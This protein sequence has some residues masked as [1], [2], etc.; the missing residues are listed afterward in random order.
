MTAAQPGVRAQQY[1]VDRSEIVAL[2][3][4]V[5]I[6]DLSSR[7]RQ[8]PPSDVVEDALRYLSRH[9]L[10]LGRELATHIRSLPSGDVIR[11]R[12]AVT[13]REAGRRLHTTTPS[14]GT[15][16]RA[17]NLARLV[18]SLNTVNDDAEKRL[19]DLRVAA[20]AAAR[21]SV[22]GCPDPAQANCDVTRPV[23]TPP[24]RA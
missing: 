4:T 17:Q 20:R 8:Q 19:R 5:L 24:R 2:V 1:P 23:M 3:E 6:W 16:L 21:T 12:A 15:A 7:D 22:S 14:E 11:Q 13:L 10:G 9:V 18:Q